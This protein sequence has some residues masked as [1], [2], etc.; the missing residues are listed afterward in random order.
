[1]TR[2]RVVLV[3]SLAFVALLLFVTFADAVDHGLTIRTVLSLPI[4]VMLGVGVVG[5]LAQ[6]PRR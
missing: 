3:V 4:I 2:R 6:P 5:A 1:M